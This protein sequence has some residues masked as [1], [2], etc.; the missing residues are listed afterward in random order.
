M[1]PSK[2]QSP[3]NPSDYLD[4]PSS[5]SKREQEQRIKCLKKKWHPDYFATQTLTE[6]QKKFINDR[7][8]WLMNQ[9]PMKQI[10]KVPPVSLNPHLKSKNKKTLLLLGGLCA[11]GSLLQFTRFQRA[12]KHL[13][14]SLVVDDNFINKD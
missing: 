14:D 9:K 6:N 10:I 8:I 3:A 11:I 7:F 5:A 13:T 2:F 4:I 12:H 1:I